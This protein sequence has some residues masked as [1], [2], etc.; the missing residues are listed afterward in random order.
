MTVQELI[1]RL[2]KFP[3]HVDVVIRVDYAH[4]SS[5]IPYRP[6][7]LRYVDNKGVQLYTIIDD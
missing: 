4:A 5:Y 2:Q 3:P 7:A 1:D 6:S